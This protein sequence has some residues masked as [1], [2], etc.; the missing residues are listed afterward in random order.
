MRLPLAARS[1]PATGLSHSNDDSP[2]GGHEGG[3]DKL[4]DLHLGCVV[5]DGSASYLGVD[6]VCVCA[7]MC[8]ALTFVR[9]QLR[10]KNT[11]D[12]TR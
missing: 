8:G 12:A 4:D 10:K 6:E 2:R 9:P 5:W 1:C 3:G 11:G 7:Q